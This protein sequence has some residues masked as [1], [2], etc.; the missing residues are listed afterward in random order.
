MGKM[1]HADVGG[2]SDR[3]ADGGEGFKL[4]L[5]ATMRMRQ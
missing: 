1:S 3:P 2:V 5:T 4:Y